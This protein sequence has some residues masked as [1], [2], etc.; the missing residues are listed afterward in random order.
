MARMAVADN[1]APEDGRPETQTASGNW[2]PCRRPLRSTSPACGNLCSA[3]TPPNARYYPRNAPPALHCTGLLRETLSRKWR[4]AFQR[5]GNCPHL[6]SNGYQ[7][8][9]ADGVSGAQ[10]VPCSACDHTSLRTPRLRPSRPPLRAPHQAPTLP[11]RPGRIPPVP[12]DTA[13][14]PPRPDCGGRGARGVGDD[15]GPGGGRSDRSS[16]AAGAHD[17]ATPR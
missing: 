15:G 1:E 17:L 3:V 5:I 10:A 12:A 4:S 8:R 11:R 6:H 16:Q 9:S 14:M 2:L 13:P 7:P